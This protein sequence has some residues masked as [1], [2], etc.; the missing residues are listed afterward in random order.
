MLS[1]A[2]AHGQTV[3]RWN[4]FLK[5][6]DLVF[7]Q[8]PDELVTGLRRGALAALRRGLDL[9]SE[10][11]LLVQVVLAT[12]HFLRCGWGGCE[13]TLMG[14]RNSDRVR[15]NHRMMAT[16]AGLQAYLDH[17]VSPVVA[18]VGRHAALFG[19]LVL[20]YTLGT[21]TAVK[22]ATGTEIA[23]QNPGMSTLEVLRATNAAISD[24]PRAIGAP[25]S[26]GA[27]VGAMAYDTLEL[28]SHMLLEGLT[29]FDQGSAGMP[30]LG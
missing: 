21:A 12:A 4:C 26:T 27:R 22:F 10:H 1:A 9:A 13:H 25:P 23:R 16:A 6:M 28:M 29:A 17:V 5:G 24:N 18:A 2:K 20:N 8:G 19:F 30:Q 15:R 14:V 11:G 3:I 7:S